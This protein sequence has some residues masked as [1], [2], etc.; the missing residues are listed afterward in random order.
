ML[1]SAAQPVELGRTTDSRVKNFCVWITKEKAHIWFATRLQKLFKVFLKLL[2]KPSY[3][4]QKRFSYIFDGWPFFCDK[5][6]PSGLSI[7]FAVNK[8]P[9]KPHY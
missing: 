4:S 5:K 2:A 1:A 3:I 9:A 6:L 8:K 7:A